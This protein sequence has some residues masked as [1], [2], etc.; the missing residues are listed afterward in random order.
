MKFI[1]LSNFEYLYTKLFSKQLLEL[2]A[3][4]VCILSNYAADFFVNN[5]S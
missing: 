3:P 5:H 4:A 2:N 1:V